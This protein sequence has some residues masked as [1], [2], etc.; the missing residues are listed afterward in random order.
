[1]TLSDRM[2]YRQIIGC[3]MLNPLLFIEY[4]DIEPIDFDLK[5]AR[6]C[7][8]II[9]KL[10]E[11]GA[12]K[13]SPIEVDQEVEKY[14]NSAVIYKQGG[15]L[16]FLKTAYEFAELSNFK[17]YYNRLKKYSLLRQLQKNKYD[18]SEYY[19][20]DKDIDNPL[21][22]VQI[23][24]HFEE[25]SLEDI[26]NSIEKKYNIIR[27]DFLHGGHAQGDPA[28]GIEELIDS[29]RKMPNIGPSLEGKIFSSACR[30]AR[31]GCF[32]LKSASTS[33]GK[34][35]TAV[36]DACH[37]AYPK[38]WSHEKQCFIEEINASGEY[39]EPRKVLFIVTEMDK[40]ELQTIMLAYLSG[41]NEN[42][43]LT[44]KYDLGEYSRVRYA[45][46]IMKEYSGYF[47]I[48]EI[49][50]PN[51]TNVEATIKKY[52]TVDGIKYCFFD[53]IHTT[54]SLVGQFTK[55]NLREDV[56]LMLL[57]NQLKQLAKDYNIFISSATQVNAGAMMDDGEFKNETCI[58]GA[59]SVADKA[60][61][62]TIMMRVSD[63]TWNSLLPGLRQAARMGLIEAK[64]VE[65]SNYRPTH[66]IDVYK[67]RRGQYKNVRI[68]INLNLGNGQRTDLF[69][70]T[71]DN[72][73]ISYGLDLFSSAT[74]EMLANW[75]QELGESND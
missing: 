5:V 22:A 4:T 42:N 68:W 39:R 60:D 53:Y 63:K 58:R 15:G 8:V 20:E 30:G 29:L 3:L 14:E 50:E 75:M 73:P 56:V 37:L 61:I 26:L 34:T 55:N 49:S 74:E 16:D 17:M 65:D 13:L 64:Y 27:N 21:Q 48:E 25:S 38:R 12:K 59:K 11:Q 9:K 40:E 32:Y 43:I 46:K 36:F 18:I 44:G 35:R 51:L 71:A 54:A 31:M 33:A 7:F 41:V 2:A 57:A 24:E 45:A 6:V 1:M 66:I 28:E 47:I 19:L 62:G 10:Y 52:A 72:Q 23:Q 67:M 69:M 70:T